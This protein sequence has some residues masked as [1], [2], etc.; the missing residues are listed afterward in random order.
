MVCKHV[1]LWAKANCLRFGQEGALSPGA[2]SLLGA[3]TLAIT[4]V[5]SKQ[6][7]HLAG[8]AMWLTLPSTL[9][10]SRAITPM[11]SSEQPNQVIK[12]H[13]SPLPC[14]ISSHNDIK[15]RLMKLKG[16]RASRCVRALGGST[17]KSA[18]DVHHQPAASPPGQHPGLAAELHCSR[19]SWGSFPVAAAPPA[20]CLHK[21]DLVQH[22]GLSGDEEE[23]VY[24]FWHP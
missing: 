18:A 23:T 16:S 1:H 9:R 12:G 13:R 4:S 19:A 10:S 11:P 14:L 21:L 6:G 22:I 8:D 20:F 3:R 2:P 5:P 15:C 7:G 17:I 24:C